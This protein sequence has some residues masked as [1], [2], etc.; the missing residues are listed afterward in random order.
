MS[1][2]VEQIDILKNEIDELKAK[3]SRTEQAL[4]ER[5]IVVATLKE[6]KRLLFEAEGRL[7]AEKESGQWD[8]NCDEITKL[9]AKLQAAETR[10]ESLE[11]LL[12]EDQLSGVSESLLRLEK[13][14]SAAR[15][16]IDELNRMPDTE[17]SDAGMRLIEALK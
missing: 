8:A 13:I 7:L 10:V 2:L 4:I 6:H 11:K 12:T 14:E 16:C 3:L 9:T 5:D 15:E 1:V 17:I